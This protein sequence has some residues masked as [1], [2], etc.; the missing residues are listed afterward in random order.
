MASKKRAKARPSP[1]AAQLVPREPPTVYVDPSAAA[2]VRLPFSP[3]VVD[4]MREHA[5]NAARLYAMVKQGA[6]VE[7]R[8]LLQLLGQAAEAVARDVAKV[9]AR[10]R[11]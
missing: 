10:R 6:P 9:R 3:E 5:D 7:P 11:G 2:Y 4:A 8:D 1:S